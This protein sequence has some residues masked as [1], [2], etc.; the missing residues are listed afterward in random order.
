MDSSVDMSASRT[1]AGF[2]KLKSVSSGVTVCRLK[3]GTLVLSAHVDATRVLFDITE[4]ECRRFVSE[5]HE[6]LGD[7]HAVES[8]GPEE[9][10]E[11]EI[12]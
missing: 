9:A 10:A 4:K 12:T 8:H 2:S 7:E 1:S 6:L 5:L 3:S 11:T